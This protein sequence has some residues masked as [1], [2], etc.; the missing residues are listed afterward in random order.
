MR[1]SPNPSS[2]SSGSRNVTH[3]VQIDLPEAIYEAV[4]EAANAEGTT[5]E[6]WI[7]ANLTARLPAAATS[8]GDAG[9]RFR[10]SFGTVDGGNPQA[11]DNDAIDVDLARAYGDEG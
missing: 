11:A 2:F 8:N 9:K 7:L 1:R 6:A 3:T 4:V 5:A 10:G